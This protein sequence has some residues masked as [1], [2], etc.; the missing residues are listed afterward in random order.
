MEILDVS[1]IMIAGRAYLNSSDHVWKTAD[2]LI[3]GSTSDIHTYMV[4]TLVQS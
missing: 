2:I 3:L 1:L 4:S